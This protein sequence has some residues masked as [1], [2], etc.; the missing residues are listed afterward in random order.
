MIDA[1]ICHD[2]SM[3]KSFTT[4]II[5]NGELYE[6]RS[7]M[8]GKIRLTSEHSLK[9]E[10]KEAA[11]FMVHSDWIPLDRQ[12]TGEEK[13]WMDLLLGVNF[14]GGEILREQ[15]AKCKV[16]GICNCGCKSVRIL[17]DHSVRIYPYKIRVPVEMTA[18]QSNDIPVHFLLHVIDGYLNELEV[19]S[20][21]SAPLIG[22]VNVGGSD[23]IINND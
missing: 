21:D 6:V 15:V 9:S 3:T 7:F 1:V 2:Y 17:P 22:N 18:I 13:K 4:K 19:F 16:T 11:R 14:K 10:G 8:A 23:L 12:L 5:Y 20:A